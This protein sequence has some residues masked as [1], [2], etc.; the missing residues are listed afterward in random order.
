MSSEIKFAEDKF[1]INVSG[2]GA[3]IYFITFNSEQINASYKLVY[4]EI[5]SSFS[6]PVKGNVFPAYNNTRKLKRLLQ[7]K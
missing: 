7:I 1:Q 4:F 5:K 2:F 6:V 3:G